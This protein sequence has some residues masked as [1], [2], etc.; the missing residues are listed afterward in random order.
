V[1][2]E[3]TMWELRDIWKGT[4]VAACGKVDV[5]VEANGVLGE[6]VMKGGWM[7]LWEWNSREV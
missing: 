1:T 6:T 4:G 3:S 7:G 5:W 2:N